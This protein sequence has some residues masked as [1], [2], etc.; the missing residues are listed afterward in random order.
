VSGIP[1]N[2]FIGIMTSFAGSFNSTSNWCTTCPA[3]VSQNPCATAFGCAGADAGAC[4]ATS[5]PSVYSFAYDGT[6]PVWTIQVAQP[7]NPY[8]AFSY[9]FMCGSSSDCSSPFVL[10]FSFK[11]VGT[12]NFSSAAEYLEILFWGDGNNILGIKGG[13]LVGLPGGSNSL[14]GSTAVVGL[15]LGNLVSG[16]WVTFDLTIDYCTNNIIFVVNGVNKGSG[17]LA[18]HATA[19]AIGVYVWGDVNAPPFFN[20]SY[21]DLLISAVGAAPAPTNPPSPT[22][23]GVSPAPTAPRAPTAP[24]NGGSQVPTL[25]LA[26]AVCGFCVSWIV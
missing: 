18:G 14:V 25:S 6:S 1:T 20:V 26:A 23:A 24:T 17:N 2:N 21:K 15:P 13:Q 19:L 12:T 4:P 5:C 16:Q 3:F 10:S 9:L 11:Y 22:N 8:R 7:G